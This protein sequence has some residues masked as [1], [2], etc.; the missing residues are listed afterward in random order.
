[1]A[2]RHGYSGA[3]PWSWMAEDSATDPAETRAVLG[4]KR[5]PPGVRLRP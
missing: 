3:F 4:W 5:D 2:H 1:M